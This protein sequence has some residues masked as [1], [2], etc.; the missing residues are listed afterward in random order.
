M[1]GHSQETTRRGRS[2]LSAG[3]AAFATVAL[4]ANLAF[5]TTN[6]RYFRMGDDDGVS[7]ND[8][9]DSFF[10]S[11][12]SPGLDTSAMVVDYDL[13][14]PTPFPPAGTYVDV[15]P[16]SAGNPRPGAAVG[17]LAINF[18]GSSERLV[19]FVLNNPEETAGP[20]GTPLKI[21]HTRN[22]DNVDGRGFQ[23]YA[24]PEANGGAR[25]D[26]VV[27]G[28]EMGVYVTA[29]GNWGFSYDEDFN[30]DSDTGVPALG[31][32]SISGSGWYHLMHVAGINTLNGTGR[33][34]AA[35]LVNGVVVGSNGNNYD[36]FSASATTQGFVANEAFSVASSPDDPG[37][38]VP[39]GPQNY[40]KGDIDEL[41]VFVF[42][43][44]LDSANPA[45]T[46][47]D[48]GS[49]TIWQDNG[50]IA[51]NIT[52]GATSGL[53]SGDL[54]GLNGSDPDQGDIDAFV[55]G[56]LSD[57]EHGIGGLGSYASGDMDFDGDTDLD[58]AFLL[59][60]E[61]AN[62][63]GPSLFAALGG[64]VPEPSSAILLLLGSIA[65]IGRRRRS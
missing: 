7:A 2:Y 53:P 29:G 24:R 64:A 63:G 8:I 6:D 27:D 15:S 65:L 21:A 58:D 10:G 5:A 17:E 59:H 31:A 22:Y 56:W 41:E 35:M 38:G 11:V 39:V 18:N 47:T 50:Y 49:F 45:P 42:G 14:L 37:A 30:P 43:S 46:P 25:Q 9:V 26:V 61:L 4:T 33:A 13:T 28:A 32:G 54:D 34:G 51:D 12:N 3:L 62:T 23:F 19:S 57:N 55:A 48:Y 20:S 40:Y 44:S 16:T 60:T 36:L 1:K 52:L